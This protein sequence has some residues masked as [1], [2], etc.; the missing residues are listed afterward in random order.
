M[1]RRVW[2]ECPNTCKHC[3]KFL[4]PGCSS[5][6]KRQTSDESLVQLIKQLQNSVDL[7]AREIKLQREKSKYIDDHY[8]TLKMHFTTVS[9]KMNLLET[10]S[11]PIAVATIA[12]EINENN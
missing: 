9:A 5:K 8:L 3:L 10:Q 12:E 2:K 4:H 7:M 1:H 6:H 11:S